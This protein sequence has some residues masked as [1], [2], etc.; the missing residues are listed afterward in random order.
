MEVC[1]CLIS[2]FLFS[3][4]SPAPLVACLIAVEVC[5][6]IHR[7]TFSHFPC[8]I[9]PPGHFPH[10]PGSVPIIHSFPFFFF[11]AS[12]IPLVTSLVAHVSCNCYTP[13]HRITREPAVST[14]RPLTHSSAIFNQ[15]HMQD[16]PKISRDVQRPL[17]PSLPMSPLSFPLFAPAPFPFVRPLPSL[18][19]SPP[20]A[21]LMSIPTVF[22]V[23]L[24]SL[25]LRQVSLFSAWSV[26]DLCLTLSLSI[27]PF[28]GHLACFQASHARTPLHRMGRPA[29]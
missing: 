8:I 21:C 18:P 22:Q 17:S 12:C 2:L 10:C 24:E 23:T 15:Q 13:D 20:L 4:V 1:P 5:L 7:S 14:Q 11:P 3:P 25:L 26:L 9:C 28:P 16:L 29:Q 6:I 19:L 27:P